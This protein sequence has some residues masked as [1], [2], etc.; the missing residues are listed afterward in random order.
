MH[1]RDRDDTLVGELVEAWL[2]AVT[3]P[4]AHTCSCWQD[5]GESASSG[6]SG[7]AHD[8]PGRTPGLGLLQPQFCTFPALAG[9]S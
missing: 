5:Q 4:P 1:G 2:W 7:L 8:C 9:M 3:W 6:L